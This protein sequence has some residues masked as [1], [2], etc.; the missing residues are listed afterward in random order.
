MGRGGSAQ[1]GNQGRRQGQAAALTPD[2]CSTE[3]GV[4]SAAP[5]LRFAISAAAATGSCRSRGPRRPRAWCDRQAS[6]RSCRAGPA[7]LAGDRSTSQPRWAREKQRRPGHASS[8]SD[9][10]PRTAGSAPGPSV[11]GRG[12]RRSASRERTGVRPSTGPRRS[13]RRYAD[14]AQQLLVARLRHVPV[15]LGQ[16]VT[17]CHIVGRPQQLR[18][19]RG[20]QEP[21][22]VRQPSWALI[23]RPSSR[24]SPASARRRTRDR[25]GRA[26]A[27]PL[28]SA[29]GSGAVGPLVAYGCLP[30][31]DL[32]NRRAAI[33]AA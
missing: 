19:A 10:D 31:P 5:A 12:G 4:Q 16:R 21:S 22:P 28:G 30:L 14:H 11:I 29:A 33:P 15:Q 24:I 6:S 20:I 2:S 18:P 32:P 3:L 13:R 23:C 7:E 17:H 8:G 26:A 1:S 27:G 9:E 25:S